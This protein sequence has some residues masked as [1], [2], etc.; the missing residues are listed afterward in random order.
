MVMLM[1]MASYVGISTRL[2]RFTVAVTICAAAMRRP[3]A[4]C[5]H[6]SRP[7]WLARDGSVAATAQRRGGTATRL[8]LLRRRGYRHIRQIFPPT[9]ASTSA[10]AWRAR[11]QDGLV[12]GRDSHVTGGGVRTWRCSFANWSRCETRD[13]L[14]WWVVVYR[15]E[16][17]LCLRLAVGGRGKRELVE[18]R[19]AGAGVQ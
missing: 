16:P 18:S 8:M 7:S 9:G 10:M 19:V 11:R 12:A 5:C 13:A 17:A 3:W 14:K 1:M 6:R 4:H 15:A 2:A